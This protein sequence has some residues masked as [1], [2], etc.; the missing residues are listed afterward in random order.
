LIH[1]Y[2][3]QFPDDVRAQLSLMRK[4]ILQIAPEAIDRLA[5]R[6]LHIN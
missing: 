4:L 1:E 3:M 6:C 2:I 5:I